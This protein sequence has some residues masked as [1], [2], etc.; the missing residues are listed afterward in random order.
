[1]GPWEPRVLDTVP[2]ADST[3]TVPRLSQLMAQFHN[4]FSLMQFQKLS[5]NCIVNVDTFGIILLA[6]MQSKLDK[7]FLTYTA[8]IANVGVLVIM[9]NFG[10]LLLYGKTLE[11]LERS[12]KDIDAKKYQS[13]TLV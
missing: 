10:D 12:Y 6:E 7:G 3:L 9:K 13:R 11:D 8:K 2:S 1:M 4:Q 5:S